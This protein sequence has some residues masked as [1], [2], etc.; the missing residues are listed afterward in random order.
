MASKREQLAKDEGDSSAIRERILVAAMQ[1]FMEHGFA[2]TTTLDIATRAR[3]SKRELYSLVGNKDEMLAA[4]VASRG[5]RMRLPEG[6]P[7]I[8]DT[9]GLRSA[10]RQYGAAVLTELF[11]P[12]V[13]AVFRLGIAEAKRSPAVAASIHER[14][15]KPARAALEALLRSARGIGLLGE[16]DVS[17]MV[18]RYQGLLWGDLMPWVLL[19]TAAAPTPKDIQ[20][21]AADTARLFLRLYGREQRP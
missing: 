16:E 3:V 14:G 19:G 8:T 13:L 4:C 9:N 21:R 18:A 17:T 12:G 11:S 10:L 5:E 15:R 20:H 7:K 6:F 2:A 1:A